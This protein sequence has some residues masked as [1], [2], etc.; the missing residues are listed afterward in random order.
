MH[1]VVARIYMQDHWA[2]L[3]AV[4]SNTKSTRSSEDDVYIA[5]GGVSMGVVW[6]VLLVWSR[7][8]HL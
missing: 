4:A 5:H 8:D 3:V 6:V 2:F 1:M 7:V